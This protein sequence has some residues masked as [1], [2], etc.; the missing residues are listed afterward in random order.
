MGH[1]MLCCT[2]IDIELSIIPGSSTVFFLVWGGG[3]GVG[4]PVLFS[5]FT[6]EIFVRGKSTFRR[7]GGGGG[8]GGEGGGGGGG[9]VQWSPDPLS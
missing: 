6:L 1:S 2:A 9:K 4:D 8:G 5:V 3:G 7:W